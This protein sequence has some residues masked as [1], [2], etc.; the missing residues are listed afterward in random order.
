[1]RWSLNFAAFGFF[2]QK[3]ILTLGHC[4]V[5]CMLL[6]SPLTILRP[7]S[8]LRFANYKGIYLLCLL[9]ILFRLLVFWSI[10]SSRTVL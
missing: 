5:S 8:P 9:L 2:L 10:R 3:L 4:P 1:V 6:I 7:L